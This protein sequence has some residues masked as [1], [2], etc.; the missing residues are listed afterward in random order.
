MKVKNVAPLLFI[1]FIENAFKY[2]GRDENGNNNINIEL[3]L[4]GN[5]IMFLCA[6]TYDNTKRLQAELV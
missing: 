2:V 4:K 3:K 6:N 5:T 1:P